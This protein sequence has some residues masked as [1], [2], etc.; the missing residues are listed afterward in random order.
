VVTLKVV[1]DAV[2]LTCS[3]LIEEAE[4]FRELDSQIGDGD[5]GMT[6]T[7]GCEAVQAVLEESHGESIEELFRI[8]GSTFTKANPSSMGTLV[9]A[10]LRAAGKELAAFEHVEPSSWAAALHAAIETMMRRGRAQIGDKTIIDALDGSLTR[11]TEALAATNDPVALAHALREGAEE[12]A[13]SMIPQRSRIG[14]ASWQGARTEGVR[15]PGA[16]VWV[17]AARALDRFVQTRAARRGTTG[18]AE[19]TAAGRPRHDQ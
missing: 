3:A 7:A 8:M 9:G 4:R 6:I 10:G 17:S 5:L 2:V 16:E 19:R 11:L 14:R 15:D 12:A 1:R 18:S 13:E